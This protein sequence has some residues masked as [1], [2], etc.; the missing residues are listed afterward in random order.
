[1]HKSMLTGIM[2]GKLGGGAFGAN[3]ESKKPKF[4]LVERIKRQ[5]SLREGQVAPENHLGNALQQ[6]EEIQKQ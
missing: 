5:K 2:M 4:S 1:M 6:I 3:D